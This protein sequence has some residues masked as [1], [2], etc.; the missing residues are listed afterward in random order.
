MHQH[1]HCSR[2][3]TEIIPWSWIQTRG[4]K[5]ISRDGLIYCHLYPAFPFSRR[6]TNFKWQLS[7]IDNCHDHHWPQSSSP[8]SR[9]K[10]ESAYCEGEGAT[11][12][13]ISRDQLAAAIEARSNWEMT[14][15]PHMTE[16]E[17]SSSW[18]ASLAEVVW[19]L[20]RATETLNP[21]VDYVFSNRLQ[22][23]FLQLCK[24][25]LFLTVYESRMTRRL[26]KIRMTFCWKL[27]E[28]RM[29]FTEN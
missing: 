9:V 4:K 6:A 5:G 7:S 17:F 21:F 22:L 29:N 10:Y 25:G 23:L 1:H 3:E 26:Y 19:L 18:R 8:S 20:G 12:C 14:S 24:R 28:N 16:T 27:F 15:A 2:G 13:A 11:Y